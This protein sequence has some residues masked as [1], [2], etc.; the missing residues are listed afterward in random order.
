MAILVMP[1]MPFKL[2]KTS[3]H[4]HGFSSA[5]T[6]V[7]W[8]ITPPEVLVSDRHGSLIACAAQDLPLTTHI[9][10]LHHL[11]GNVTT[12]LRP[13]LGPQWDAFQKVFWT[14]YRAVSPNEFDRLWRSMTTEYP[15][16]AEYLNAELYPCRQKWAWAWVS[17]IFTAGVLTNGRVESENRVNKVLGGPK[18]TLLQLFNN[19]NE[20]TDGQTAREMVQARMV[21]IFL[22]RS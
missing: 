9:Y 5:I 8:P 19:L 11:D 10:C 20:R 3:Q 15:S 6:T 4:T 13:I 16:A 18:K 17:N 1:G 7:P 14:A 12:Q 21:S 2:E 22:L